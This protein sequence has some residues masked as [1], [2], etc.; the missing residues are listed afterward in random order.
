MQQMSL[1]LYFA[2]FTENQR[3]ATPSLETCKWLCLQQ[4]PN[5][6]TMPHLTLSQ[7][8]QIGALPHLKPAQIAL[9]IGKHRFVVIT[10]LARNANSIAE[11]QP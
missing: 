6:C 5:C 2:L 1:L 9:R 4:S 10:E 11:Y 7:R 8:Y 3:G